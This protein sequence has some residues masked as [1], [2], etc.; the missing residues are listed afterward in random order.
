M[1]RIDLDD[2]EADVLRRTLEDFVSDLRMEVANTD[3]QSV[4]DDLKE[5]ER[6]LKATIE[7]LQ[8][9]A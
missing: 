4:R 5:T 9:R 8:R 1:V 6:I 3:S 2:H 7:R